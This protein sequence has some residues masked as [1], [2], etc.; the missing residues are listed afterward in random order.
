MSY[1][2][3]LPLELLD[4][5]GELMLHRSY[6]YPLQLLQPHQRRRKYEF[7]RTLLIRQQQE[8]LRYL[9]GR[10][11]QKPFKFKGDIVYVS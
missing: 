5:V 6:R 10:Q 9:A 7:N 11:S 1:F 4:R 8:A 3:L 2:G